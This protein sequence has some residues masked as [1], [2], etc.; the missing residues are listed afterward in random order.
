VEQFRPHI[1]QLRSNLVN[2]YE[3]V[4]RL[5][6]RD[7]YCLMIE[8]RHDLR[9]IQRTFRCLAE[10]I[11]NKFPEDEWLSVGSKAFVNETEPANHWQ[12]VTPC[13]RA[14]CRVNKAM[15]E[16]IDPLREKNN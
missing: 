16:G 1:M 4:R 13:P 6:D 11:E 10:F 14:D 2:L 15:T 8:H 12:P 9:R 5:S 3:Q 7:L